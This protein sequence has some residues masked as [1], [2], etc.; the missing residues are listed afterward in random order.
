MTTINEYARAATASEIRDI[1]GEFDDSVI[2]GILSLGATRDEVFDAQAWLGSDDYL[3]R[4]LGHSLQ[5]RAAQ[6]FDIL[7]DE[8]PEPDRR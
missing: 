2:A 1:V 5:G 7:E 8:L 3:Y 4:Q 6:V